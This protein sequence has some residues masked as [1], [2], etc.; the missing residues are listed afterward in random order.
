MEIYN[1]SGKFN[2]MVECFSDAHVAKL[3]VGHRNWLIYDHKH[4]KVFGDLLN[5]IYL[6]CLYLH[7]FILLETFQVG[8]HG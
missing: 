2:S 8:S 4:D 7:V 5:V 3:F 6:L 1:W